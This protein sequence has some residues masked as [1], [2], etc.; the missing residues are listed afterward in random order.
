MSKVLAA[1]RPKVPA[2]ALTMMKEARTEV[3]IY[4]DEGDSKC[5]SG[6]SYA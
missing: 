1:R 4:K 6:A 2:V 3:G 5:I